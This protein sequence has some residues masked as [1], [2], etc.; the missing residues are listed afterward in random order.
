MAHS[1]NVERIFIDTFKNNSWDE[2]DERD[3]KEY[4]EQ[5]IE[6]W[7][8]DYPATAAKMLKDKE[9]DSGVEKEK[10]G[11]SEGGWSEQ[12]TSKNSSISSGES[13]DNDSNGTDKD[14]HS[15]NLSKGEGD[16]GDS[17]D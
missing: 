10:L 13:L 8:A 14:S 15:S 12:N 6:I 17:D 4:L 5:E 1:K 11:V 9:E 3:N 16:Y 2:G 7:K